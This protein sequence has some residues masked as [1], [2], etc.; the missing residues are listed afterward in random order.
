MIRPAANP[1]SSRS[2]P[3]SDASSASANTSTTIQ[4][5]ASCELFSIVR[6][7]SGIVRAG[8]A[9]REHRDA[10]RERD[11]RDQDQ[12]VVQRALRRE[13]QRQQQDRAELAD[14][15]GREQVGAEPRVAARRVSERTGISVPIAVVASAEPT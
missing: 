6:S 14:R 10:H 11:E 7:N 3:S 2:R 15:A 1:P 5:T 4:R 9:H 12:R 13:D 8:R